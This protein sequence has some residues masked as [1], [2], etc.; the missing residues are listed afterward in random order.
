MALALQPTLA[1]VRL[2][3]LKRCGLA[4]EGNIPRA[5]QDIIDERINSAQTI[6]YEYAPWLAAYVQRDIPLEANNTDYDIPDDTE[7]GQIQFISVRRIQDGRIYTLEPGIRPEEPNVLLNST[8]NMPLRYQFIDQIIRILPK[9]DITIYDILRLEYQQVPHQLLQDS[10]RVTIHGEALKMMGE[11]MVKEHFGGQDVRSL[12]AR[13]I[14]FVD[15]RKSRGSDGEGFQMGG[16][17]SA[18][19]ATQRRNRFGDLGYLDQRNWHPW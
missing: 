5:I 17:Q 13:L 19:A 12:E 4:T 14:S 1:E 10:D 3:V 9:A 18:Y 15:K 2:S 6:L 7:P 11:I 8:A 16:H